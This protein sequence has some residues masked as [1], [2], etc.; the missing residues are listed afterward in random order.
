VSLGGKYG[1]VIDTHRAA[2][3]LYRGEVPEGQSVLHSC[4]VPSCVNPDHLFLG[5]QQDNLSDMAR[6]NR[7]R[8]GELPYGVGRQPKGGRFFASFSFRGKRRYLGTYDTP[9]E[10]G[11]VASAEKTRLFLEDGLPH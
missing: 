9:E 1:K 11:A 7:G 10:A 2:W 6:K 3:L 5:S 8:K 4:D